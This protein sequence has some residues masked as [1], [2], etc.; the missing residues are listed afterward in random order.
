MR[1]RMEQRLVAELVERQSFER[2]DKKYQLSALQRPK[3]N[4]SKV[5]CLLILVGKD[6]VALILGNGL[7][8]IS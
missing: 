7:T 4:D 3:A 2:L 1:H 8:S 6:R 5:I